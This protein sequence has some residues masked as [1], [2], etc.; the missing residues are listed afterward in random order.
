MF[1]RLKDWRYCRS[2]LP[3]R[4]RLPSALHLF[5]ECW[6]LGR[7]DA[8]A[9]PIWRARCIRRHNQGRGCDPEACV[10]PGCNRHDEPGPSDMAENLERPGCKTQRQE[11]GHGRVGTPDLCDPPSHVGRRNDIP[12]GGRPDNLIHN[13]LPA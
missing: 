5:E 9:Q 8:V 2:D 13:S 10:V 12:H 4:R 11:K 7:P 6:P 1:G 3:V